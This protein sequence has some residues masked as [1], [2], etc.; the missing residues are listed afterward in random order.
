MKEQLL[1]KVRTNCDKKEQLFSMSTFF[2]C[3]N[4]F[5]SFCCRGVRKRLYV[6]KGYRALNAF[7]KLYFTISNKHVIEHWI[8]FRSITL[9]SIITII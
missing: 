3:Q 2:F 5:K 9:P 4:V 8:H 1:Y 7:S 6:G